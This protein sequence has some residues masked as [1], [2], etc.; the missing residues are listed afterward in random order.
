MS[1]SIAFLK[2][3]DPLNKIIKHPNG[4]FTVDGTLKEESSIVDPIVL[5]QHINP[6]IANYAYISEFSRF[7]YITDIVNVK[8][9]LWRIYM[10]CDVLYTFAQGILASPAII[11]KSS[12]NYNL[13][14]DNPDMKCY[15]TPYIVTKKFPSGFDL[16]TGSYI[17]SM[18]GDK[19]SS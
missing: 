18:I 17:L 7:Y 2:N 4:V 19:V 6:K 15:Q 16:S 12:S 11:K 8:N 1:F 3:D 5:I 10:H 13:L 14:L 9:N